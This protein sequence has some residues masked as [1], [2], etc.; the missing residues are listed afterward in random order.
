MEIIRK[1][2]ENVIEEE[3]KEI[4]KGKKVKIG[5]VIEKGLY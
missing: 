1:E 5:K 4:F 2:N 3:V